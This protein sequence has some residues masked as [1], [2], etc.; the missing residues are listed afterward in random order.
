MERAQKIIKDAMK[1][2]TAKA[3]DALS[4]LKSKL[5]SLT[6]EKKSLE[7]AVA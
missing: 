2:A 5:K 6:A 7:E 1:S 4:A 3:K